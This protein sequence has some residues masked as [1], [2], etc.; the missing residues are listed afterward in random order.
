MKIKN[1]FLLGFIVL[2]IASC[3]HD[4]DNVQTGYKVGDYYPDPNVTFRSP[5]VVASGTAPAG[6]VFWLDPQDSRHGKIVSLD[7]TKAHW[8]TI[9]STTSATDTG[10]GLTNILQIK[11]Q[12]DTFSHYPAF[13]WT[14]RKN[15]ADETYSNASAT[16]VW[17]LPAKNE[18]KVL[19]AG[20]SGITSLWDDFS[21]MPDYN[22]PNRAA[23][24]KAFD[25]K[26]EAAGGNAFTTNYY[27]SSSEGDNS[28]AW[29]VN[30]SNGY[31]TNLNESSPDMARCI[32]NF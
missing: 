10:N 12:D 22:N 18:L 26:L 31:T 8:S 9:Y 30:F 7:E 3:K 29:E 5:G 4:D 17:Y 16:G 6:I 28:L 21:N 1:L 15:K 11:K 23:A 13:A 2:L 24:R 32:L 25:S 14:H 20:Y 19:Y 27:W